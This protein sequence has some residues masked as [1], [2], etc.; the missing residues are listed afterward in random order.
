MRS[1]ILLLVAVV[2][3][4][5]IV[6]V[7]L[8]SRSGVVESDDLAKLIDRADKLVV[9][10]EPRDG[11][12]VLFESSNRGD[13]DALKASLRVERPEKYHHCMCDGTPAII[14]YAN[15]EQIAQV[16]NHHA[17][18][19]RCSLWESD[20]RL[21]DAEAFLKWFDDRN[22][23]GPRR[24][25]QAG[26]DQ[27]KEW[28][29]YERKWAEGMPAALKPLWPAAKRSFDPDLAPLRNAL[30]EQLPEKNVRILALF[31]WYGSG[32]GPW[33]GFPSY[34]DIAEKM[35][36][37]YPTAELLA[38]VDRR[39]LTEAQTE[40]VARLF[41]GWAFSRLRPND[42]KLLPAD[43]K[44]RLLKHSLASTDEDKRGR[45]QRAFGERE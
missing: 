34:E 43:L 38:A 4:V 11:S 33:S 36:L 14:L 30:A 40:G 35:L 22:I 32:A 13:L 18:L 1:G 28:Q 10:Q 3:A 17:K 26:L 23:P 12:A 7:V 19:V 39:E 24:E 8:R 29:G 2:L 16:T 21:V 31:S 25:F 20:A 44:A 45:A 6:I 27:D 15:G 9:L 5:A 42:C 37:E 41:G